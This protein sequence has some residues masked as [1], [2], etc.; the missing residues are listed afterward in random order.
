MPTAV[1]H[2]PRS[3]NCSSTCS[4]S[5]LHRLFTTLASPFGLQNPPKQLKSWRTAPKSLDQRHMPK[6][7]HGPGVEHIRALLRAATAPVSEAPVGAR[8]LRRLTRPGTE[9]G[10]HAVDTEIEAVA[11]EVH[12]AWRLSLLERLH[13]AKRL[14][15]TAV[16]RRPALRPWCPRAGLKR[17][18]KN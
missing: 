1:P 14:E 18:T 5:S 2:S 10:D 12:E 13:L 15:L 16:K 4:S 6:A 7:L 11:V 8:S 3:R 17:S 9:P